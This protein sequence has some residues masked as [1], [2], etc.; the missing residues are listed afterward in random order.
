MTNVALNRNWRASASRAAKR[1]LDVALAVFLLIPGT[2]IIAVA[3]AL[4]WAH[5]HEGPIYRQIRIGRGGVPFK[6]CKLRS[7]STAAPGSTVDTTSRTDPRITPIGA[8]IR[9]TKVDELPQLWNVLRGDMSL[10]GPRPQV[11]RE[12]DL[13]TEVERDLLSVR[14]GI[15]D[16]SSITFSDLGDIVAAAADPDIAYNQ[17]V[18][19]GKSR[20]GLF[21]VRKSS[22]GVDVA[23]MILTGVALIHGPS[24][25]RGVTAMLRWQGADQALVEIAGRKAPLTPGV[26]PGADTIVTSRVMC[27]MGRAG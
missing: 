22:V 12:V 14:P 26:P 23:I 16:Y 4:V 25:R 21:Y 9:K 2:P 11:P 18:R 3:A 19:P 1:G 5:D 7:M 13:Y 8:L 10:V 27:P 6:L 15:T 24:A 20:L 17:L